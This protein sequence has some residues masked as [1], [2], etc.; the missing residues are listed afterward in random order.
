MIKGIFLI[1]LALLLIGF[2]AASAPRDYTMPQAVTHSSEIT[3]AINE[4]VMANPYETGWYSA[5]IKGIISEDSYIVNVCGPFGW[6]QQY[7]CNT[8]ELKRSVLAKK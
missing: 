4:N 6:F 8:E 5:T 7:Q 2:F 3:Y 1:V